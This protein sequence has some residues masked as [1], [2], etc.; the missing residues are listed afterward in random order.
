MFLPIL[1]LSSI[2]FLQINGNV[3]KNQPNGALL[4]DPE[5]CNSFYLCSNEHKFVLLCPPGL[6]FSEKRNQCETPE[7]ADC[8]IEREIVDCSIDDPDNLVFFPSKRSCSTYF[9][10]F[11]GE[12]FKMSC[13]EDLYWDQKRFVCDHQEKVDCV[14]ETK[15]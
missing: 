8:R 2:Y 15:I 12:S 13:G 10:C 14:I 5:N 7:L 9:I 6:H 4:P 1:I 11:L 3:C